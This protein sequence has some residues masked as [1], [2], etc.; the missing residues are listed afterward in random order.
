MNMCKRLLRNRSGSALMSV[1]LVATI[2]VVLT[3]GIVTLTSQMPDIV[4]RKTDTVRAK[5]IAEAGLN[6]IYSALVRDFD[7]RNNAGEYSE[8]S[9]AGGSYVIT[10]LPVSNNAARVI[11]LGRYGVATVRVGMDVCNVGTLGTEGEDPTNPWRYAIFANGNLRLNG[12]PPAV[13]GGMH[14]NQEFR[15]NGVP[16]NVEGE[17]T[18][19]TF[20]WTGG[21]LPSDQIGT[22]HEIPF[23]Q[24]TDPYFVELLKT[25]KD[26]GAFRG[27][28]TYRQSDLASLKG[29]V[30]WFTG[31]VTLHGSFT[32]NG[33][34]IV[35]GNI[36]FQGSG[37][38]TLSGLMF[39]PGHITANG[40]TTLYLTGSMMSG[41][42]ILFNGAA[43]IF[44]HSGVGPDD[45]EDGTEGED[46]IVVSAMWEG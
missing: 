34:L 37:T 33:I 4:R 18:A 38:R 13:R 10:M 11:S 23:P 30:A 19:R 32:Y 46:K 29:G 7:Q 21:Q 24:L 12:T 41:G 26:N 15:L 2:L 20:Q 6:Q 8:T 17:V 27:P 40:S 3:G 9:F 45:G 42:N 28:G 43:S 31:D 44:T 39:T 5:A 35:T 16:S 1:L 36:T 22:F 14:S 25:A